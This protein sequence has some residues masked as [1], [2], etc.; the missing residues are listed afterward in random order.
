MSRTN[1]LEIA[2]FS[3]QLEKQPILQVSKLPDVGAM[4][5]EEIEILM[6]KRALEFHQNRISKAALALGITRSALY[7]RLEKFNI[8]YDE[9]NSNDETSD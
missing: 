3:S 1:I 7:R 9:R 6:I 8:P 4:T 5:L 2:D